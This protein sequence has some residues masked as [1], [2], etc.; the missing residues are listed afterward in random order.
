MEIHVD[1]EIDVAVVVSKDVEIDVE[2]NVDVAILV[3]Y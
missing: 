3:K 1:T 2:T